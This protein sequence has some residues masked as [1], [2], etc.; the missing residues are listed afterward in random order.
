[1]AISAVSRSR[2]SPTMITLGSWRTMWRRP[3]EK[4][5]PI[6]GRTGIWLTPFNWYSTGSSTVRILRS[7]RLILS[8]AA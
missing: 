2:I 3:A 7:G 6:F 4:D 1:M 8:S 5:S